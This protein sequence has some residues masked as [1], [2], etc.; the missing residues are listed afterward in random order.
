MGP[1]LTG[2]KRLLKLPVGCGEQNM[3]TFAP[4]T[5]VLDYLRHVGLHE[6]SIE[7]KAR[8]L[9]ND[10]TVRNAIVF[11]MENSRPL[12]SRSM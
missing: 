3:A 11:L 1:T 7:R 6:P 8:K 5:V 10:G 12:F 4:N 2:L 9:L